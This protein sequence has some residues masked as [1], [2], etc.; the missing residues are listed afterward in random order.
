MTD[1][2]AVDLQVPL[3]SHGVKKRQVSLTTFP[4]T[5]FMLVRTVSMAQLPL[6]ALPLDTVIPGAT[7]S[8]YSFEGYTHSVLHNLQEG[9][10]AQVL[11]TN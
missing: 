8:R 6:K 4:R 3:S 7:I 5:P 2:W 11:R 10:I 9:V 1:F